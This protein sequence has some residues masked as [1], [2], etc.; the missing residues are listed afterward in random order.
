LAKQTSS[1]SG[2]VAFLRPDV[3]FRPSGTGIHYGWFIALT[4]TIGAICSTPGQTNGVSVFTD[5]L[6]L[7]LGLSR[8]H[9]SFAYLVGTL[10]S[11]FLIIGMGRWLDR[12]GL[13]LG[14]ILSGLGLG[15]ALLFLSQVDRTS[16]LLASLFP[17]SWTAMLA[18][19]VVT[20]GFFLIRFFG[21][22]LMTLSSRN[23]IAKW[24]DNFRGR[25]SSYSGVLATFFFSGAPWLLN[26]LVLLVGWRL[27]WILLALVCGF[28]FALW[29]WVWARDNPE[30]C[31]LS[32]DAGMKLRTGVAV[33]Q[34]N[35]M[36]RE[37]SKREAVRT[38]SFWIFNLAFTFQGFFATGYIFHILSV[39]DSLD[40]ERS[41]LLAAF[42]PSAVLSV[43]ITLMVGWLV[44]K[45]RLKY[46]LTLFSFGMILFPIGLLLLPG[47][48]GWIFL[49]LGMAI[50]GGC[51]SP[52]LGTVWAR[53]YGRTHLGSISGFNMS[54]LVIG[55]ALGPI[56]FS[57][58]MDW[59]GSYRAS[60]Y[61]GLFLALLLFVF[62]LRADN[63]QRKLGKARE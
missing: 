16:Y 8:T 14:A 40:V 2:S 59:F 4:S 1:N 37:L 52:I 15:V 57:L 62:S 51:F 36:V 47:P 60:L 56:V 22:G 19:L 43:M 44:D 50:A 27:A 39:A 61:L 32:M 7:E 48:A 23:L 54:S 21:Q 5:V 20:T 31:G 25:V 29:A 18:F 30:E 45:T 34:D 38:Y 42:F 13:R 33:N 41:M 12:Y 17:D 55:S 46:M 3:P 53:Y 6:I 24:F 58:S 35:V 26:Q 10:I 9:I 28:C 49:V 11:G 63:P